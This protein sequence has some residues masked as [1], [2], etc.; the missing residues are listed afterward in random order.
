M[1]RFLRDFPIG[2]V[3]GTGVE[4][5]LLQGVEFSEDD[6]EA[7]LQ[8]AL[9]RYNAMTPLT[10]SPLEAL[11][12]MLQMWGCTAY[13]LASESLRQ[14]RNQATVTDADVAPIGLDDKAP[15]YLKMAEFFWGKWD[16][17][18]RAV[19]NQRNLEEYAGGMPSGYA[20]V[21]WGRQAS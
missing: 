19:K 13:L 1:R 18:A 10:N 4:N 3:P 12:R 20:Y 21:S 14:V 11:P 8:N 6:V 7:G 17:M 5:I 9:D 2:L 15:A 16:E